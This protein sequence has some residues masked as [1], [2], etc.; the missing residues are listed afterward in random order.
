M[1]NRSLRMPAWTAFLAFTTTL[2]A[3]PL[4]SLTAAAEGAKPDEVAVSG[5]LSAVKA[6]SSAAAQDG[7]AA[8]A[9]LRA[10]VTPDNMFRHLAALQAIADA[11][12]GT[13]ATGTAGHEASVDYVAGQLREAGYQVR[14]EAVEVPIVQETQSPRLTVSKESGL[15]LRDLQLR[16]LPYSAAGSVKAPLRPAGHGCDKGDFAQLSSGSI[17]L[18][19][20]GSCSVWRKMKNAAAAGAGAVIVY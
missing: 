20:Q 14:F 18:V 9:A 11:N 1:M 12:G 3:V 19:Q 7:L 17:A 5:R 6:R 13:R 15:D 8:S 16:T 2:L 10:A 4:T